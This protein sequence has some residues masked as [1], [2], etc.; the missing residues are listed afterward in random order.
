MTHKS[1]MITVERNPVNIKHSAG[2][3]KTIPSGI[4]RNKPEIS[5]NTW[6]CFLV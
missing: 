2:K 6:F 1:A 5:K 3:W 4:E